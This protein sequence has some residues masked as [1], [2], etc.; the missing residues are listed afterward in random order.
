MKTHRLV[1]LICSIVLVCI[2][3]FL[4]WYFSHC[5]TIQTIYKDFLEGNS[6][7]SISCTV[8]DESA[9]TY[10]IGSDSEIDHI[11]DCITSWRIRPALL[12]K[13]KDGLYDNTQFSLST[14]VG[15][16]SIIVDDN[17][18]VE[19]KIT[20]ASRFSS[21]NKSHIYRLEKAI[22]LDELMKYFTRKQ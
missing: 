7:S 19:I 22:D 2:A 1:V 12:H 13:N 16:M 3:L 21:L 6:V 8:F 4:I 5:G 14:S 17:R 20:S 18:T 11:T 9:P 15:E 10:Y